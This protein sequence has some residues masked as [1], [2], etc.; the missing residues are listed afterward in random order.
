MLGAK[1]SLMSRLAGFLHTRREPDGWPK[2]PMHQ[3][4]IP[5]RSQSAFICLRWN[6]VLL[7]I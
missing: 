2:R 4:I 1:A 5:I 6:Q 3:D 7:T